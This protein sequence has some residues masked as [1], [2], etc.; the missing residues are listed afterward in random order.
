MINVGARC[1]PYAHAIDSNIMVLY[2]IEIRRLDYLQRGEITYEEPKSE[3]LMWWY[4]G[5]NKCEKV[6]LNLGYG[7]VAASLQ[8][9]GHG[10]G[11]KH[12]PPCHSNG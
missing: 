11:V 4:D 8:Q 2:G 10:Y 6:A 12:M 1:W 9:H 3:M 7:T 5:A